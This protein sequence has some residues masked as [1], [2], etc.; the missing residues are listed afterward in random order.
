[1]IVTPHAL[2]WTDECFAGT[3]A[4]DIAAVF[5]LLNNQLP[6]D[7][8]NRE[9]TNTDAWQAKLKALSSIA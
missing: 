1:M 9:V 7:I 5:S 6:S 4:A 8:V 2:C 3:G